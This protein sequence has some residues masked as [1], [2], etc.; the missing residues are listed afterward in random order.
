[1][2]KYKIT[3]VRSLIDRPKK[4]KRTMRALGLTKID[5]HVIVEAT[6]QIEGMIDKVKHLITLEEVK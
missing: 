6:P 3:Q 1:M 2:K 5:R 4:Q